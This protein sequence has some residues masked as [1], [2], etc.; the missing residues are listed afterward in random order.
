MRWRA[1]FLFLSICVQQS[2]AQVL[3]SFGNSRTGTAG[4]QF[5]KIGPDARAMGMGEAV[6]A[7]ADDA[8]ALYWNPAGAARNAKVELGSGTLQHRMHL[9]GTSYSFTSAWFRSGA[10][11]RLGVHVSSLNMGNMMETTEFQPEGTGRT[12][13]IINRTIGIS[14]ARKLTDN[15]CFGVTAK[16][17]TEGFAG[18]ATQ[19]ILFDLGL[20]YDVDLMHTRFAVTL[21]NYGINVKPNGTVSMLTFSGPKDVTSFEAISVPAIFRIGAAFDP[22]HKDRNRLTVATQLN[23]YTD[24]N[25]TL[26]MGGEYAWNE[27]V[28]LRSG[29]EFG[30]DFGSFPSVGVGIAL[31]RKFGRL[32]F[33]YGIQPRKTI[34]VQQ[35]FGV[36]ITL[37]KNS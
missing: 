20:R 26:S 19:N 2:Q 23:H 30:T 10:Y 18:I 36:V 24:N 12:F 15:F 3:P 37:G 35:Q 9:A 6:S 31:K 1:I 32:R 21:S 13:G 29:Y 14:W 7:V 34:G 8:S 17:A 33:D 5:L 28:M 16:W 11:S 4:M 27:T 22:I 25:E